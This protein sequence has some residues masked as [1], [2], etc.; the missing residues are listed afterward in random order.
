VIKTTGL[1]VNIW[2]DHENKNSATNH[3]AVP[4]K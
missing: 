3:K 4:H 2:F 1:K